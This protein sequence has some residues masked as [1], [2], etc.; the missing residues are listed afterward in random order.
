MIN[1]QNPDLHIRIL[2]SRLLTIGKNPYT[3]YWYPNDSYLLYNPSLAIYSSA[4][5]VTCTP[6]VLWVQKP[7]ASLNY[8]TIK[9]VWWCIEEVLLFA[10]I[11]LNFLMVKNN[12][13][14]ILLVIVSFFFLYSRNWWLHINNGQL[15]VVYAFIFSLSAYFLF[16]QKTLFPIWLFLLSTLI[17]PFFAIAVLP[18]V[19]FQKKT[20]THFI[21]AFLLC[22]AFFYISTNIQTAKQYNVAMKI[23]ATEKTNGFDSVARNKNFLEK[24][25][26]TESC[27]SKNVTSYET[28]NFAGCLYSL[29][30]YLVSL[31][32]FN[33]NTNF[34]AII[35]LIVVAMS[36]FFTKKLN[37]RSSNE[38]KILFSFLL[39]LLCE[40]ITPASRNP[41]SLVQ[42]LGCLAIVLNALNNRF[43]ILLMI[44]FAL[45]H[46]FP[47]RFNYQREL[48]EI[49]V[50][51]S[52]V[53]ALLKNKKLATKFSHT[54]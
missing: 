34:Y 36:L 19:S 33:S 1:C 14:F 46:D 21:S 47:F 7:L 6:F 23:Y 25:Y 15:Y 17:R 29:Q 26:I 16:C 20:I 48:G 52:Y 40:L 44:G 11:I 2:G 18:F 10:T 42:Y 27:V 37:Y 31:K 51:I 22:V 30:H 4:N 45:N 50:L 53:A 38:S 12:R 24:N 32:Y 9:F 8:C 28:I 43:I 5:G 35:L 13:K 3:Y 49:L 54:L 39:Y 41:Y